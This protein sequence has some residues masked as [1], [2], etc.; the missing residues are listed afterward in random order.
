MSQ[1]DDS[2]QELGKNQHPLRS[3]ESSGGN[4]LE[5]S[6]RKKKGPSDQS[7]RMSNK[8]KKASPGIKK[9]DKERNTNKHNGKQ[10][11]KN[12]NLNTSNKNGGNRKS[13]NKSTKSV[14]K[15]T[16]N[17][18]PAKDYKY[19]QIKKLAKVFK[20]VTIN[21]IPMYT[22]TRQVEIMDEQEAFD[23]YLLKLIANQNDQSIYI[24]FIVTPSDPDFPFDLDALKVS[25]CVP[26]DYPYKK[27]A[28]STIYVL[29]D[30]IPRGF[31][32]NVELGYKKIASLANGIEQDNII[33]LQK[34]NDEDP[35]N[36]VGIEL[37]EG[38]GLLSQIKTLDKYLEAFLRQEKRKTIKIVKGAARAT[39]TTSLKGQVSSKQGTPEIPTPSPMEVVKPVVK[40]DK[41]D[42]LIDRMSTKL[43]GQ[44]KLFNRSKTHST[45]K[46]FLPIN[47]P[48]DLPE[49]WINQGKLEVLLTIPLDYPEGQLKLEIAKNFVTRVGRYPDYEANLVHNFN[50]H[51]FTDSSLVSVLNYLSNNL[52]V[53]CLDRNEFEE[54][55]GLV[56]RFVSVY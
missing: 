48:D 37:V 18:D 56:D 20:P 31:A 54:Y 10:P 55:N 23:Q 3:P 16:R 44:I 52:N 33:R 12:I 9:S 41:R 11:S 50:Q 35:E 53:F 32:V 39:G 7:K 24:S 4:P 22:L 14:L 30:E 47:T 19:Q 38:K 46:V 8:S 2:I 1:N 26:K 15:K 13:P 29:N 5:H 17:K 42:E 21:G 34:E 27:E 25:L 49:G 43:K 36:E 45:Y 40:H 51:K 6:D 28:L